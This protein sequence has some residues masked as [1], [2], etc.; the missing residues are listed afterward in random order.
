[1]SVEL[2]LSEVDG[3]SVDVEGSVAPVLVVWYAVEDETV[4]VP[5]V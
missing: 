3:V 2:W 5:G 1:M 4:D